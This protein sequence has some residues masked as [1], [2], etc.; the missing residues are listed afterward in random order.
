MQRSVHVLTVDA[1]VRIAKESTG[2]Y[3]V[4]TWSLVAC[5]LV[6]LVEHLLSE[7]GQ[8][9]AYTSAKNDGDNRVS[10]MV[11]GHGSDVLLW[12]ND[13][14]HVIRHH[15]CGGTTADVMH[16]LR[17]V[18]RLACLGSNLRR[19]FGCSHYPRQELTNVLPEVKCGHVVDLNVSRMLNP[20]VKGRSPLEQKSV[21][22]RQTL[23]VVA[24]RS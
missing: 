15:E 19:S 9:H 3:Q 23:L 13:E 4:M 2:K 18:N 22:R 16:P 21:V 24:S 20:A 10:Q 14:C 5:V 7:D 1:V 12:C 17:C 11:V 6:M 8:E